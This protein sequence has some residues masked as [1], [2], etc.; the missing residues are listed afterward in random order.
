MR[1]PFLVIERQSR[2]NVAEGVVQCPSSPTHGPSS[3]MRLQQ[4]LL[5]VQVLRD[6]QQTVRDLLCSIEPAVGIVKYPEI[7]DRWCYFLRAFEPLSYRAGALDDL[8]HL[9]RGPAMNGDQR[10]PELGQDRKFGVP[11]LT[12]L[13]LG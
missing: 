8:T 6:P 5:T 13:W 12:G 2:I 10:R 9:R 4:H 7:C 1:V 11:T 3:M